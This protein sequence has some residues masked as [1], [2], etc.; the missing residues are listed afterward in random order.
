MECQSSRNRIAKGMIGDSSAAKRL[1]S[2]MH[3]NV[4]QNAPRVVIIGAGFG[5]LSVVRALHGEKLRVTVID[6]N[7][8]HLF[9]PLLY[10]VATAGLSPADIANPIRNILRK[11]TNVEVL[12]A[13]V[14]GLDWKNRNILLKDSVVPYDFLI[15]ATGSHYNYFGHP[16]WER[17]A[18]GLKTITDATNIRRNI[19]LSL[20]KAEMESDPEKRRTLMTFVIV[21][22]GPTGVEMAG[23][24]AELT[25]RTLSLDFRHIDPQSVRILLI[26]AGDRI[27]SSFPENL[28]LAAAKTLRKLGV[29]A[30]THTSVSAIS[31]G[32]VL[33]GEKAI[34][35]GTLIWAAGVTG[36]SAGRWLQ[37]K[38]DRI[39]RVVVNLDLTVEERPGVYVIG[40]TAHFEQNGATLPGVAQVAIQQGR[41]VAHHIIGKLTQEPVPTPFHY[42]DKGNLATVGRSFAIADFGKYRSSG[43]L[44]WILWWI[45][46]IWYLI[47]F[48][49]RI[50]V[51]VQWAWAYFTFKRGA[52][53][54]TFADCEEQQNI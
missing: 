37:S 14:V 2:E 35:C 43:F 22:A 13:E 52:R 18:P 10:Q 4:N 34:A 48:Q 11:Q 50:L 30:L 25:H 39:G 46:H 54:I 3:S 12:L 51:M 9:Q 44:T 29:E 31:Q 8:H 7:N 16:E 1:D 53:L 49:S 47:D 23:A 5:G 28:S 21:G 41:Y 20:E 27:L 33:V 19:L 32:T 45:I 40:D 38:T 36:S 17:Y 42:I 6:R 24:I 26:E 15:I